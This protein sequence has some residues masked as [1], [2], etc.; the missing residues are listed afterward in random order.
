MV[1]CWMSEVILLAIVAKP[2]LF[3]DGDFH[4]LWNNVTAKCVKSGMKIE[5]MGQGR[6]GVESTYNIKEER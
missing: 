3:V 6:W 1:T 2:C 5:N 4:D